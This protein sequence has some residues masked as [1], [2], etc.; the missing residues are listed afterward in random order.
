MRL[1][2]GNLII[3]IFS[4]VFIVSA[5]DQLV[6]QVLMGYQPE[7]AFLFFKIGLVANPGIIGGYFS[8][9]AKPIV[10]IPMVTLGFFL[11][12][13]L[14]FIQI[15]APVRSV[16]MRIAISLFFGG[17]FANVVDRFLHGYVIDYLSLN[18]LGRATPIF[19]FA[20]VI[21][22]VGIGMISVLQ[23]YSSTFDDSRTADLWVS[24]QFQKRYSY[25]IVG[26]GFFLVLVFGVLSYS[27]FRLALNELAVVPLIR[28]K[29]LHDYLI[30]FLSLSVTFLVFLFLVGKA[31]SAHVAKPILNFEHYLRNLAKGEYAVFQVDEPEFNYLEKLSDDVRDHITLLHEEIE[32]LKGRSKVKGKK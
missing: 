16:T 9:F 18:L 1:R 31:L 7:G 8:E 21:Q 26:L 20:D 2:I 25:Q 14:Y 29:F 32:R 4:P 10:Q 17:A 3:I 15:F 28:V 22:L 19:N 5:I 6:K 27:F 13:M 24:P 11:L 23:F 12:V 30:L